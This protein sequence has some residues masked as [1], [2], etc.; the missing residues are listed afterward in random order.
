MHHLIYTIVGSLT[1]VP[2]LYV[3]TTNK[4]KNKKNK[5]KNNSNNNNN[6]YVACVSALIQYM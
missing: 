6:I 4:K 1:P 2:F 3:Y 5:K